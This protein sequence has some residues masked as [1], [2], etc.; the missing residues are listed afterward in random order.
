MSQV[1]GDSWGFVS[2]LFGSCITDD[3][4]PELKALLHFG[5]NVYK[6]EKL[7]AAELE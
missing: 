3:F 4:P 2:K 7:D 6:W 1:W 5:H